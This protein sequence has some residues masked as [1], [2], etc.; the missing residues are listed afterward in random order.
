ML[1]GIC[2]LGAQG[3]QEAVSSKL[4]SLSFE[5]CVCV[6]SYTAKKPLQGFTAP[7]EALISA[8]SE[9]IKSLVPPEG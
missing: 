9:N 4:L 6:R 7:V 3:E 2:V 8:P 1:I 5:L